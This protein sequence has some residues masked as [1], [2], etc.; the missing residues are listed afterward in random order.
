MPFTVLRSAEVDAAMSFRGN[1]CDA[2]S[3][4]NAA[5]SRSVNAGM[6]RS[7]F[8]FLLHQP[9]GRPDPAFHDLT[10]FPGDG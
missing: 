5:Y 3:P 1:D 7:C 4:V 10:G 9:I 6:D 8:E 2:G